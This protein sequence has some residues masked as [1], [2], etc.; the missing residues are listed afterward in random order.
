MAIKPLSLPATVCSPPIPLLSKSLE[1]EAQGWARD[2]AAD[3]Q[4]WY[5]P[6]FEGFP[7]LLAHEYHRLRELCTQGSFYGMLLQTKDVFEV[8]LRFSTCLMLAEALERDMLRVAG[9]P[10]RA[11]F[12]QLLARP[13]LGVWWRSFADLLKLPASSEFAVFPLVNFPRQELGYLERMVSWHNDAIGHGAL[14]IGDDP[15]LRSDLEE[16]LGWL[17]QLL[18]GRS[19]AYQ[20]W[21]FHVPDLHLPLTGHEAIRSW[22]QGNPPEHREELHHLHLWPRQGGISLNLFPFLRLQTCSRCGYKDIFCFDSLKGKQ[23]FILDYA[24]GHKTPRP[25]FQ[26]ER[27]QELLQ[28]LALPEYAE[29]R[30]DDEVL[31]GELVRL[32]EQLSLSDYIRPQALADWLEKALEEHDRGV[33]LLRLGLGMGKTV[34]LK[35]AVETTE[36]KFLGREGPAGEEGPFQVVGYFIN[37][38]FNYQPDGF[39]NKLKSDILRGKKQQELLRLQVPTPPLEAGVADP[40]RSLAEWL[41]FY[42]RMFRQ[43]RGYRGVLLAVDALDEIPPETWRGRS[44]LDF[45]PRPQDLEEGA[46]V[47]ATA[48]L[49]EEVAPALEGRLSTFPWTAILE[50]RPDDAANQKL[51]GAYLDRELKA[52]Y[53]D[54]KARAALAEAVLAQGEGRFLYVTFIK[55]LLLGGR[56]AAAD[57]SALPPAEKLYGHYLDILERL[58][59]PRFMDGVKSLLLSLA[60]AWEPLT[61]EELL[62][63]LGEP[64]P[65]FRLLGQLKDLRQL[66]R[67]DRTLR[68]NCHR[69]AHEALVQAVR[70]RWAQDLPPLCAALVRQTLADLEGKSRGDGVVYGACYLLEYLELAGE[71]SLK[72]RVFAQPVAGR[73]FAL[74]CDIHAEVSI[75]AR[76][77]AVN[78]YTVC[79]ALQERLR[80]QGRLLDENDLAAAYMNR[81]VAKGALAAARAAVADAILTSK[82][83][84][85][86]TN[87]IALALEHP[88]LTEEQKAAWRQ[89]EAALA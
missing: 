12:A 18:A 87:L 25:S 62:Y 50:V 54:Q 49:P 33:F 26:E 53:P 22:H 84:S 46:F 14:A 3:P 4:R 79:L 68:G 44:I 10:Y 81:G 16:K 48:R 37:S 29:D 86:L 5:A 38:N 55:D 19:L 41:N 89:V 85:F 27:L 13:L 83:Q 40:S 17:R 23:V 51:L 30:V 7:A 34:F 56:L 65:T 39:C 28:T 70:A 36:F 77:L 88:C 9:S 20:D 43:F 6:A 8:L 75:R 11:I 67:V 58:Y 74:A 32:V 60:T 61:L 59:A 73:I 63:L 2:L 15:H 45:L 35:K 52:S 72:D 78:L 42:V 21:E 69:L 31:R 82:A 57:L 24:Y 47:L 76:N 1:A 66:L 71:A 64:D 80:Q